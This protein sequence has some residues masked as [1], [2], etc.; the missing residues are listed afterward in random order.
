M[1]SYEFDK[2]VPIYLQIIEEIKGDIFSGKLKENDKVAS[3]RELALRFGV[4]PNTIQKAL[5]EL[6]REGLLRSERAIGRF[7]S[8]NQSI[9]LQAQQKK[10]ED[11]VQK[12][13]ESMQ[14]MGCQADEIIKMVEEY[15][16]TEK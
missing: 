15:L 7:V 9:I 13:V 5:T 8:K 4:N 12:Y 2:N 10:R 1:G 16:A 11:I 14:A 3:V 6:E